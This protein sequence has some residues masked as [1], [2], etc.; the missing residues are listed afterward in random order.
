MSL[1]L[2]LT[3][4]LGDFAHYHPYIGDRDTCP[5]PQP[6]DTLNHQLLRTQWGHPHGALPAPCPGVCLVQGRG[7]GGMKRGL[8]CFG[9]QGVGREL[10]EFGVQVVSTE[11]QGGWGR[12]AGEV[13]VQECTGHGD[14]D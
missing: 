2:L 1:S 4:V 11:A 14:E 5:Q 8:W 3:S 6:C 9:V 7:C 13:G 12:G 10:G